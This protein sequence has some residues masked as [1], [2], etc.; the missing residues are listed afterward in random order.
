MTKKNKQP[1][2]S[3]RLVNYPKLFFVWPLIAAPALMMLL[4]YMGVSSLVQGWIYIVLVSLVILTLGVDL[5]RTS[6]FVLLLIVVTGGLI[7]RMLHS[8]FS[9]DVFGFITNYFTALDVRYD[10]NFGVALGT[11][12]L[13]LFVWMFFWTRIHNRWEITPFEFKHSSFGVVDHSL[14]RGAKAIKASYPDILEVLFGLCGSLHVYSAN[15]DKELMTINNIPFLPFVKKRISAV[16]AS[17]QPSAA[18]RD[19]EEAVANG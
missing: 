17:A 2:R 10:P 8:E 9:L 13:A 16:L 6:G 3:I 19:D 1:P 7:T 14:A 15:G 18:S 5:D 11:L 12:L 4:E